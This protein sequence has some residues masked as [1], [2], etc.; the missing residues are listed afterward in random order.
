M[1]DLLIGSDCK[2]S[3]VDENRRL[4]QNLDCECNGDVLPTTK[5]APGSRTSGD[6]LP[7]LPTTP[8][9]DNFRV[10][11]NSPVVSCVALGITVHLRSQLPWL[12]LPDRQDSV[13]LRLGAK[14]YGM[15]RI[16]N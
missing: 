6:P 11:D 12:S 1:A 9:L 2:L 5:Q 7:E 15:L 13:L 8:F 4:H 14:K 16:S 10:A 3:V